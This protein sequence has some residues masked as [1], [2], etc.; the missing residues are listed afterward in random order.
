MDLKAPFY[1]REK[2]TE[3][4]LSLLKK[5][6]LGTNGAKYQHLN[7]AEIIADLDNP[8]FL[9]LE[10]N[11][12]VIGNITFCRRAENWYIRYFA[13]EQ[14]FQA[15]KSSTNSKK[16]NLKSSISNFFDEKVKQEI[17][18]FY[19]YIDPKNEKS[20]NMAKNFGFEKVGEL[21]TYSFSRLKPKLNK[22]VSELVD[23]SEIEQ[24]YHYFEKN[25]F[26]TNFQ[27]KRTKFYL[28]KNDAGKTLCSARIQ[29]A[30]WKIERLPGKFGQILVQLIPFIP[31]LNKLINPKNYR[32]LVPDMIT[33]ES[34]NPNDLSELFEGILA[35]EN[36]K[37]LLFW[38][39][40][41]DALNRFDRKISWGLFKRFLGNPKVDV[42]AK[43]D[44]SKKPTFEALFFVSG[45]DLI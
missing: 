43:F 36:Y 39:D 15:K 42:V 14:L 32:F 34:G 4:I 6:T 1:L 11:D 5:T 20:R 3:S 21:I 13:F 8:L 23:L 45:I 31:F 30:H 27:P 16:S 12:K 2:W 22:N 19:A 10:R 29:K 26:Y 41:K 18:C 25:S 7:T 35:Q 28:L 33:C 40:E 44:Q 9:S 24:K 37:L 17:N 38:I